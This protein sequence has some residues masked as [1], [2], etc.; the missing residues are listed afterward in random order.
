MQNA[1]FRCQQNPA[2]QEWSVSV[3]LESN[4]KSIKFADVKTLQKNLQ[5]LGWSLSKQDGK[6]VQVAVDNNKITEMIREGKTLYK[7]EKD[8]LHEPVPSQQT[9]VTSVIEEVTQNQP[10]V[11]DIK[12]PQNELMTG[13][14]LISTPGFKINTPQKQHKFASQ[15]IAA[16]EHH[17]QEVE[18]KSEGKKCLYLRLKAQPEMVLIELLPKP[19]DSPVH[20][21]DP[22]PTVLNKETQLHM[23]HVTNIPSGK[24]AHAPYNFVPLNDK[25]VEAQLDINTVTEKRPCDFDRYHPDRHTGYID[26]TIT[27]K[28]PVYIRGLLD[29]QDLKDGRESKDK[30]DFFAPNGKPAIPGSSLRGLIRQMVEMVS[31]GKLVGFDDKRL[32]FRAMA[33]QCERLKKEYMNTMTAEGTGLTG[34]AKY[35][36]KTGILFRQNFDY[37][38]V[39]CPE[40][41]QIPKS[42]TGRYKTNRIYQVKVE[43]HYFEA[44]DSEKHYVI[45]SGGMGQPGLKKSK[46]KDWLISKPQSYDNKLVIPDDD[47]AFYKDDSNRKSVSLIQEIDR[48]FKARN[49][50]GVPCFYT[51]YEDQNGN[52]HVAFGHT[53]MFRLPYQTTI[54]EHV[55][56]HLT[57]SVVDIPEAIFGRGETSRGQNDGFPGRVSFEDA[58]YQGDKPLTELLESESYAALGSPKP[59]TFQHYLVQPGYDTKTLKHYN[60]KVSIR[61]YKQYW[62]QQSHRL[63]KD[64]NT[65]PEN[66]RVTLRPV[67]ADTSFQGK[68]HFENLTSIELGALLFALELPEGCFHK[69]GMGKPL[70]LGSIEVKPRLYLSDR[71]KRYQSL[72]AEWQEMPSPPDLT[73]Y[74]KV[75]EAYVLG[76][77]EEPVKLLWQTPRLQELHTMLRFQNNIKDLTYMQIEKP[78]SKEKNGKWNE[79]KFRP[80]LPKPSEVT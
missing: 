6:K 77:L 31:F 60:D 4:Q 54:Q 25:V 69:I 30:S 24:E 8:V 66:M 79:Y 46:N 32:Y 41:Q 52:S 14:L 73:D 39:P 55:P 80:V 1:I 50:I 2:T 34:S 3:Q 42:E 68:I 21:K 47:I 17:N 74:K 9:A 61:G 72:W 35:K 38:I 23:Q 45:I 70:G 22:E 62:H 26:L 59:T 20:A 64:K 11:S 75:F 67:K 78:D 28:S 15:N 49:N 12:Q 27:T 43:R 13:T 71:P 58:Y 18:F 16:Q 7:H 36:M 65:I 56:E 51:E 40:F 19:V 5:Q 76:K 37:Y 29:A 63:S 10:V 44:Y 53:A 33:D 57:S 48:H